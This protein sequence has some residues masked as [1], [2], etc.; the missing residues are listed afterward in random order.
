LSQGLFWGSSKGGKAKR[1]NYSKIQDLMR[2]R[3]IE[4]ARCLCKPLWPRAGRPDLF[5][6]P[7]RLL[8]I[9]ARAR[10]H[11]VANQHR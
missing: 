7:P 10:S 8:W 6:Q 3:L 4:P 9:V 1:A 2:R 5:L 11:G